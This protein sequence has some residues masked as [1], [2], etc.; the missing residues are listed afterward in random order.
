MNVV[1]LDFGARSFKAVEIKKEKGKNELV[2]YGLSDDLSSL[3]LASD[4]DE[5]INHYSKALETFYNDHGFSTPYVYAALPET[6]VFTK[7]SQV[8][9]MS[10]KDLKNALRYEAEQII[11][12][13]LKDVNYVTQVLDDDRA[14]KGKMSV[15]FVAASKVLVE[16][17]VKILKNAK[18]TPLGMEPETLAISRVVGDSQDQPNPSVIVSIEA[19]DTN[20]VICYKGIV[21]FSRNISVGGDALTRAVVQNLGFEFTQAEEYKK[22]YGLDSTQVDGKVFNAL[23][24]VFDNILE[25]IKRTYFFY[26]SHNSDV[27]I[28][29]VVVCGGTALMP[30]LLYYLTTNLNLEVELGNP[31]QKVLFPSKL[32]KEKQ[33]LLDKGPS[34][35]TA[36]G[37]ALKEE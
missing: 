37:L 30:G 11:P 7:V 27:T 35:V 10:D 9:K 25:E 21:R 13:P 16:K 22:T 28:R 18:L 2:R 31:W 32:E 24:P 12:I 20:I 34:F 5:E 14:E 3:N 6:S 23:K 33:G 8:P 36:V 4:K 15:L 29:R 26:T 1:G 17:Y 19:N